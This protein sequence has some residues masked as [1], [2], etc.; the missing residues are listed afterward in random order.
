ME[1]IVEEFV[2]RFDKR[3]TQIEITKQNIN[4]IIL[5]NLVK[6]SSVLPQ[7]SIG[8]N[9]TGQPRT[10]RIRNRV[11][12]PEE[13]KRKIAHCSKCGQEGHHSSAC[14]ARKEKK[15]GDGENS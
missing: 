12:H 4:P 3:E 7:R 15:Q 2:S 5:N 14:D 8:K 6:D 10:K 9:T 13:R 11:V 1:T